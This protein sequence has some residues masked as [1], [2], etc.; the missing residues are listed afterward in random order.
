E[1]N[2]PSYTTVKNTLKKLE[3]KQRET[4]QQEHC[5]VIYTDEYEKLVIPTTGRS[6][7]KNKVGFLVVPRPMTMAEWQAEYAC[8]GP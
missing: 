1:G 6:G 5:G 8:Q 3:T 4:D 7:R 2:M